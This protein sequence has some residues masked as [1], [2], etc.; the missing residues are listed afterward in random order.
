MARRGD[1]RH[2]RLGLKGRFIP[3][4]DGYVYEAE[5]AGPAYLLSKDERAG[6]VRRIL[7]GMALAIPSA[8]F[9]GILI[10]L[11][12]ARLWPDV[13]QSF[14]ALLVIALVTVGALYLGCRWVLLSPARALVGRNPLSRAEFDHLQQRY[15]DSLP[16]R[17]P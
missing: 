5:P 13:G 1:R 9:L 8:V 11:M 2:S 12:I 17:T 4:I 10:T 14:P 16:V 3:V 15:E 7:I 6:W